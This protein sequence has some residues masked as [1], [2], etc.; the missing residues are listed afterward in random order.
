MCRMVS[1]VTHRA[2]TPVD[3]LGH[4]VV[5]RIAHLATVHDDGWGAAWVDP[6][7]AHHTHRSG[8]PAHA[9][10]DFGAFMAGTETRAC[11]VH[12]RL[13]TPGY[14]TGISNV[15]P[16]TRE[17]W[18]FAHNGAILPTTRCCRREASAS[19][20]ARRTARPTS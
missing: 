20:K 12:V 9:D 1:W 2:A 15:H 4:E 7:G 10:P 17:G 5:D 13:G 14:G 3:T 16:F 18:A 19:P 8:L 11:F 6:A